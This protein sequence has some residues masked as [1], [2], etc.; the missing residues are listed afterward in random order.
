[1]YPFAKANDVWKIIHSPRKKEELHFHRKLESFLI[2]RLN[3]VR[4]HSV[5]GWCIYTM[6]LNVEYSKPDKL[7]QPFFFL[8]LVRLN[9]LSEKFVK[10]FAILFCSFTLCLC[11][12]VV[13]FFP[14][15]SF[16]N[17]S[18]HPSIHSFIQSVS[19]P[20]MSTSRL[21]VYSLIR[22]F[23]RS[24]TCVKLFFCFP[25]KVSKSLLS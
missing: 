2:Y 8:S 9:Y 6:M 3:H 7:A 11:I 18:I 15:H 23:S 24:L 20:I 21:F 25:D 19:Q 1:M 22:S 14:N 16:I 4:L 17:P 10:N 5:T 12:V 13:A